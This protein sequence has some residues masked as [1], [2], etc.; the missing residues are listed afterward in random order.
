[1][2]INFPEQTY[3]YIRSKVPSRA[4]LS[5]VDRGGSKYS[6]PGTLIPVTPG[7]YSVAGYD[8]D[9]FFDKPDI[10]VGSGETVDVTLTP[11]PLGELVMTYAPSENYLRDPDRGGAQPLDGQRI[12]GG[13]LRPGDVRKLYPGRYLITGYSYAGDVEAQEVVV[14]AGERTEIVLKLRG[15]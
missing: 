10:D 14:T 15:E 4:T 13:I 9:G 1:V 6:R 5:S 12:V 2:R 3:D 8:S 11:E 7:R